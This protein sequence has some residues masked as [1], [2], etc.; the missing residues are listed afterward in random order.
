MSTETLERP[1]TDAAPE[2]EDTPAT[3]E[4]QDNRHLS[5][6]AHALNRVATFL[7]V[8][9][10]NKVHEQA[11][12][13]YRDRDR[14]G[15]ADHMQHLTET[16]DAEGHPIGDQREYATNRLTNER[17]AAH[18]EA[19]KDYREQDHASYIDHLAQLADEG[20]TNES[21]R[22][23]GQQELDREN[24]IASRQ[25]AM[26][27]V[28][29][30]GRDAL[31]VGVGLTVMAVGAANEGIQNRRAKRARRKEEARNRRTE[32]REKRQAKRDRYRAASKAE[33]LKRA[34][35]AAA[36]KRARR[37]RWAGRRESAA[38]FGRRAHA[39]GAAAIEAWKNYEENV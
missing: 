9:A 10:T 28:R 39:T 36:R 3:P 30:I 13:E 2:P 22:N 7:E 4:R 19:L 26:A 29:K 8:R 14:S 33:S 5:P 32:R 11:L 38:R 6:T 35:A 37:E 1:H 34:R 23:F 12:D 15:Y 24:R 16:V 27:K 25:E 18:D 20:N 31:M 17:N 21:A